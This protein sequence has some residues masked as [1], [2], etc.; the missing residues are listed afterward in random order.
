MPKINDPLPALTL[1]NENL[2]MLREDVEWWKIYEESF[3]ISER[4]SKGV[5]FER[6]QK[7]VGMAI[8]A[9]LGERTV[10]MA[11][12]HLLYDPATVYLISI[13]ISPEERKHHIGSFLFD[14]AWESGAAKLRQTQKEPIGMVW[15]V[16][17]PELANTQE[18]KQQRERRIQFYESHGG[19]ILPCNYFLPPL[20]GTDAIPMYLMF[21]PAKKNQLM[22]KKNIMALVHSMY[23]Q[24]YNAMNGISLSVLMPLLEKTR[25]EKTHDGRD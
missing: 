15:E 16:E 4:E 9:R 23:L 14:Y 5:I 11:S 21:R 12:L 2:S 8:H 24:N 13:A 18:E 25:H 22:D 10:G 3:P 20:Q 7:N 6:I 1:E 19:Q 17:R